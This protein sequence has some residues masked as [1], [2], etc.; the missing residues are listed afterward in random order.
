M[1]SRFDLAAATFGRH[2]ALPLGV[3]DAIRQ[4]IWRATPA[5]SPTRVLDLGAGTGRIGRAFVD[6]DDAYVG[7]DVS[8]AMLR[9]FRADSR[10]ARLVQASGQQLPL[11]DGAFDVVLLM[12]VLSGADD[13]HGLAGEAR[14]VVAPAGAIVVG[15]TNGP[16]SG[17][18]AQMRRQLAAILED[19][20]I[21]SHQPRQSRQQSLA[22]L[23]SASARRVHVIAASWNAEPTPRAF[24]DRHRTGARFSALPA[25]AQ[26]IALQTLSAWA[27]DTFGSLDT[28]T[29]EEYRFELDLFEINS[30]HTP[31]V[32]AD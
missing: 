20:G 27:Q 31:H 1:T 15:H 6:A 21:A 16:S 7:V 9:E 4:A 26:D 25:A 3:P 14:R 11:R 8:L 24:L 28:A 30:P 18:E 12:Q 29:A 2:R 23:E 22:W 17:V 5:R 32:T 13:W 19:L 10:T